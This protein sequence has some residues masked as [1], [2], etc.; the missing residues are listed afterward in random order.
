M[1]FIILCGVIACIIQLVALYHINR[2]RRLLRLLPFM[3]MELLPVCIAAHAWLT[4]MPSGILG[5]SFNVAISGW[6]AGAILIGCVLAWLIYRF[7][8][9]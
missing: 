1:P 8:H 9:K 2:H 4:K 6:M 7:K 3:A 5:W